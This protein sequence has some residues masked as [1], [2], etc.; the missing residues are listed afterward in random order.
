MKI[1]LNSILVLV[2]ISSV[3]NLYL[4]SEI[5]NIDTTISKSTKSKTELNNFIDSYYLMRI[6]LIYYASKESPLSLKDKSLKLIKN[7]LANINKSK[8]M[9]DYYFH[10]KNSYIYQL[11]IND[12]KEIEKD[13]LTLINTPNDK[14]K[15]DIVFFQIPSKRNAF[16]ESSQ[17]LFKSIDQD[18]ILITNEINKL[19][20]YEKNLLILNIILISIYFILSIYGQI[21]LDNRR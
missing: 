20:Y 19:K 10:Y 4:K 17:K 3:C 11:M 9:M 2:I 21:F 18:H 7:E 16:R 14:F 12:Y 15:N 5:L 6:S 13:V 8:E 1:T